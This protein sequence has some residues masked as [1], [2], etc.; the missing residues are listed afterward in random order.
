MDAL[1]AGV[2]C[3]QRLSYYRLLGMFSDVVLVYHQFIQVQ[4]LRSIKNKRAV[5]TY[6]GIRSFFSLSMNNRKEIVSTTVVVSIQMI[7]EEK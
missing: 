7:G 5:P 1:L 3:K 6:L 4:L 2:Q